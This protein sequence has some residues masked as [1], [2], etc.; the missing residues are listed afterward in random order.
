MPRNSNPV[1]D[2]G[3]G[4][5]TAPVS[6]KARV[7][8]MKNYFLGFQ[9]LRTNISKFSPSLALLVIDEYVGDI[10]VLEVVG[11]EETEALAVLKSVVCVSGFNSFSK[12][13]LLKVVL[14]L[15]ISK[16]CLG[17]ILCGL[18][19]INSTVPSWCWEI[20]LSEVFLIGVG[21]TGSVAP[22]NFHLLGRLI[23]CHCIV[24]VIVSSN[25]SVTLPLLNHRRPT[26]AGHRDVA[27]ASVSTTVFGDAGATPLWHPE[28]ARLLSV[29]SGSMTT[30]PV[31][32]SHRLDQF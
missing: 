7:Q 27:V 8:F 2:T 22:S 30:Q 24:L 32:S 16:E 13:N 12:F 1:I 21:A 31:Q 6:K 4:C 25:I 19:N 9:V 15:P 20:S 28:P 5:Y 18:L 29:R 11:I 17:G 14:V 10:L 3:S 23:S 26:A